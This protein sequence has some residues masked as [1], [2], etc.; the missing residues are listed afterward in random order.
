MKSLVFWSL[1]T[2]KLVL[3]AAWLLVSLGV[4][5][6]QSDP[7][8]HA[9]WWVEQHGALEEASAPEAARVRKVFEQVVHAAD[10]R[11][12]RWPQLVLLRSQRTPLALSL[13]D[14]SVLLNHAAL[15]FL[16][17]VEDPALGDTR[18]AFVLGHELAHLA[19]DDFWQAE[20]FAASQAN[21][22]WEQSVEAWLAGKQQANTPILR[23]LQADAYGLI[24]AVQAGFSAD[25]ILDQG[26]RFFAD[27]AAQSRLHPH[28]GTHPPD[29]TR[30]AILQASLHQVRAVQ[31]WFDFGTLLLQI[32]RLDDARLLL[33]EYQR[34]FPGRAVLNNLGVVAYE[35]AMA[36][37]ADCN[38]V[39]P[40][41]LMTTLLVD[42]E[43]RGA[44]TRQ[45]GHHCLREEP[46]QRGFQEADRYFQEATQHDPN[47]LPAWSNLAS[48]RLW[49]GDA[50][51]AMSAADQALKRE[52]TLPEALNL[53][54]LALY[55]FGAQTGI[56]TADR[57]LKVL[58]ILQ[59]RY[60]HY[61]PAAYNRAMLLTERQRTAAAQEA[62]RQALEQ[63]LPAAYASHAREQ[64]GEPAPVRG[65]VLAQVPAPVALG[66]ATDGSGTVALRLRQGSF[67]ASVS[68]QA[69]LRI[70][71]LGR[72]VELV[73]QQA[74][75]VRPDALPPPKLRQ[76]LPTGE[77]WLYDDFALEVREGVSRRA[78]WFAPHDPS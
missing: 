35:Q 52:A 44:G 22:Q 5:L 9:A 2:L 14:G 45:G 6:A 17:Q 37:L 53:K 73:Q 62:W 47:Y 42:V 33:E 11:S 23:E 67:R 27:W 65:R 63:P 36:H 64:L 16:Y 54:A 13:P 32:G 66:S 19:Q 30:A 60:P 59:Q 57:A 20:A 70:L 48:V 76:R 72:S 29:A 40:T 51:G 75:A 50:S 8:A 12:G 18:A 68:V 74:P 71:R 38:P 34:H 24:Y 46:V 3:V 26:E 1:V 78:W 10:K 21:P 77:L 7:R 55:R 15:T 61:A 58:E 41:T 4:A 43:T 25:P 56:D 39:L 69:D 31:D 49:S 28:S